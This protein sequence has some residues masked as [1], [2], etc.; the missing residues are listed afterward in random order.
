MEFEQI[1]NEINALT[2]VSHMGDKIMEIACNPDSSL[3]ELVDVI[4]YDQGTTANLLKTCNSAYFGLKTRISSVKQAVAYLG[5]EKVACLVTLSSSANNFKK[6]QSG[7]DLNEGELWR[8]SVSS[9]LIAQEL[10]EKLCP[11]NISL[12]FTAALL[13]DIGK[14]VLSTYVKDAFNDIIEAVNTKGLAFVE[15]EREI[16]GIDHAE[17]GA[18]FAEKWH[19]APEMVDIIRHH[20]A[21]DRASGGDMN[22]PIVYLADSICMMIGIGGGADGLSYRYDQGVLDRLNFSA[23]DLEKVIVDFW[24]K[25]KGVEDLVKL[26]QGDG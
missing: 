26:S 17:L 9:A 14:V 21:P 23:G 6:A 1:I 18:R 15:A 13:K 16:I 5:V 4:K 7:Y 25:L 11:E 20:H 10:A 2:P 8:Y 22:I 3:N 12:I 24:E 19:F